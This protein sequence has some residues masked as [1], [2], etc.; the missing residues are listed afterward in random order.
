[1]CKGYWCA[2]DGIRSDD[3]SVVEGVVYHKGHPLP[4]GT[5]P[6]FMVAQYPPVMSGTRMEIG[7][8]HAEMNVICNAAAQGVSTQG[9]WL[10][11]P[12]EPCMMCA[13]AIHHAGIAKVVIVEDGYMGGKEG[14][15]YL[16]EQ[17]VGVDY[18]KGPKDPRLSPN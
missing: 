6:D 9:A 12:A 18:V 16:Q 1:M 15:L 4:E 7:C 3:L 17:C 8:H 5:D 13:K 2:R 11:V 10:I 14:V